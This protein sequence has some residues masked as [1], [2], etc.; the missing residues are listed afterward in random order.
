MHRKPIDVPNPSVVRTKQSLDNK[1]AREALKARDEGLAAFGKENYI[2]AIEKF[3]L[4]IYHFSKIKNLSKDQRLLLAEVYSNLA[5]AQYNEANHRLELL[6]HSGRY[7]SY[8]IIKNLFINSLQSI[9]KAEKIS[10]Q[11]N[12]LRNAIT[13]H[14]TDLNQKLKKLA[15]ILM[16]KGQ[17]KFKLANRARDKKDLNAAN[18]AYRDAR[19]YYIGIKEIY[20]ELNDD[21]NI[22]LT[23]D[24]KIK[25][26]ETS[27]EELTNQIKEREKEIN[28]EKEK[29][30]R[31]KFKLK[32]SYSSK[33]KRDAN[34]NGLVKTYLEL[35]AS[36]YN[37]AVILAE[38][39]TWEH[40][41]ENKIYETYISIKNLLL[42]SLA[43]KNAAEQ[44][45][46]SDEKDDLFDKHI[47]ELTSTLNKMFNYVIDRLIRRGKI[48]EDTAHSEHQAG[49]L[50]EAKN[51]YLDALDYY[52]AANELSTKIP[53]TKTIPNFEDAKK[54]IDTKLG[55]IKKRKEK[56]IRDDGSLVKPF[57]KE[58][59]Y[60]TLM[61]KG[62]SEL[63]LSTTEKEPLQFLMRA[64]D[65]F[66]KA[67]IVTTNTKDIENASEKIIECYSKIKIALKNEVERMHNVIYD[68]IQYK[69]NGKFK[70]KIKNTFIKKILRK[71]FI[72]INDNENM[73]VK[74]LIKIGS[75][76]ASMGNFLIN[77]KLAVIE[78]RKQPTQIESQLDLIDNILNKQMALQLIH[79]KL[80]LNAEN[81]NE[82]NLSH[83]LKNLEKSNHDDY[84][85]IEPN[86]SHHLEKIH[87]TQEN[88][89]NKTLNELY[90]KL[91]YCIDEMWI[92]VDQKINL[93]LPPQF[94]NR[95]RTHFQRGDITF[96]KMHDNTNTNELIDLD[97]ITDDDRISDHKGLQA[98]IDLAKQYN[99]AMEIQNETRIEKKINNQNILDKY[100]QSI[101]Q[102][103]R[104]T[105]E[106]E[107]TL[108]ISFKKDR[109]WQNLGKI[110]LLVLTGGL[111]YFAKPSGYFNIFK[112]KPTQLENIVTKAKESMKNRK[113]R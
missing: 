102:S 55:E 52:A 27:Q 89:I 84:L 12:D 103:A 41:D 75:E 90:V 67:S 40:I 13:T 98:F 82:L 96:T 3:N 43:S 50:S 58:N 2:E 30:D 106:K 101:T 64:N 10:I 81:N 61:K 23:L 21:N 95:Q 25:K 71:I 49:S 91:R 7:E 72:L 60:S 48:K 17:E 99:A 5:L 97:Q 57:P 76:S 4:E 104:T 42:E 85:L 18:N 108:K 74:H 9:N 35:A 94:F 70:H 100:T 16:G 86:I 28:D 38:N 15:A 77:A 107:I 66:V 93:S 6:E 14:K 73:L 109:T 34:K 59:D 47:K 19:D 46:K 68:N 45:K 8:I 32:T 87:Q 92:D 31:F 53:P 113:T 33:F 69:N 83:Q 111:A 39:I 1:S 56:T 110:A 36:Q 62:E 29:I 22:S 51:S 79:E 37:L 11:D 44:A 88:A 26:I 78:A 24:T 105:I 80:E 112:S 63:I 65:Y 54:R 20:T